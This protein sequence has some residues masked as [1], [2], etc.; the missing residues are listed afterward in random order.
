MA[1]TVLAVTYNQ[2][3]ELWKRACFRLLHATGTTHFPEPIAGTRCAVPYEH[4]LF[5]TGMAKLKR[6][7]AAGTLRFGR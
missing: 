4:D 2:G 6:V 3:Q 7:S 1:R 5:G